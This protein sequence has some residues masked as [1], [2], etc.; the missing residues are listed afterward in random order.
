MST[1]I[2][3]GV[4]VS[5]NV[6]FNTRFSSVKDNRFIY[7]Y[8]IKIT[9]KSNYPMKLNEREWCIFDTLDF[10][11]IVKGEGVVGEQPTIE[12]GD[13]FTYTSSCDLQSTLGK[14]EGNYIFE[15]MITNEK[16]KVKIPM[17]TLMYPHLLN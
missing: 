12:P 6:N 15:N 10:P 7:N 9:N 1:E 14:M 17:F 3:N 11:R 5:V 8:T 2:T 13:S 16:L 4:K